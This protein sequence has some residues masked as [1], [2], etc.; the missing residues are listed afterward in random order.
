MQIK[1]TQSYEPKQVPQSL[2]RQLIIIFFNDHVAHPAHLTAW[3]I[4]GPTK[5]TLCCISYLPGDILAKQ[6]VK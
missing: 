5:G 6:G 4:T 2:K 1:I 3:T